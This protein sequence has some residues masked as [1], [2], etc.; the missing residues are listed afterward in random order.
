MAYEAPLGLSETQ[1]LDSMLDLSAVA[2][3]PAHSHSHG[4]GASVSYDSDSDT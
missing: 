1:V 4:S 3:L 2:I